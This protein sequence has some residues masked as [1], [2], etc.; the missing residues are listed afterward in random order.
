[1]SEA[2]LSGTADYGTVKWGVNGGGR[3]RRLRL[4][5]LGYGRTHTRKTYAG[6]WPPPA[7]PF[8]NRSWVRGNL[9]PRSRSFRNNITMAKHTGIRIATP[10][11]RVRAVYFD[12]PYQGD[13]N[14]RPIR[15]RDLVPTPMCTG[16]RSTPSHLREGGPAE[17][18]GGRK[19]KGAAKQAKP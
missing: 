2:L 10:Y 18:A 11:L 7:H 14:T 16:S 8:I 3:V 17:G 15:G 6:R 4:G 9:T 5:H 13:R 1:M 19:R 12:H